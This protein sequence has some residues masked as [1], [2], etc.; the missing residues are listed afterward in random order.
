MPKDDK[1]YVVGVSI[2]TKATF[3]MNETVFLNG[4]NIEFY[5]CYPG[6]PGVFVNVFSRID[7]IRN[8]TAGDLCGT[9]RSKAHKFGMVIVFLVW[10]AGLLALT[11]SLL[12]YDSYKEISSDVRTRDLSN[13]E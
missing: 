5:R 12:L 1:L 11:A 10:L 6:N 4:S 9:G 3:R 8:V 7:W 2:A 13:L